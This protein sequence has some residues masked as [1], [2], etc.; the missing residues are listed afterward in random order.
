MPDQPLRIIVSIQRREKM[1]QEF[2][3]RL[4]NCEIALVVAHHRNQHFF[5]QD[6]IVGIEVA[7]NDRRKLGQ[8]D[9][10]IE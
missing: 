4:F 1:R 6:K 2:S 5:R 9:H 7:Q 3:A 10:L 8:V